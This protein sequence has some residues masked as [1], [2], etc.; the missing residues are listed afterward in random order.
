MYI[1]VYRIY[2]VTN[3]AELV[4]W[5]SLVPSTGQRQGD[6]DAYCDVF[7]GCACVRACEWCSGP[8]M[9]DGNLLNSCHLCQLWYLNPWDL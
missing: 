2:C 9:Y 8:R 6:S 5:D 7:D 1:A 4:K 3:W